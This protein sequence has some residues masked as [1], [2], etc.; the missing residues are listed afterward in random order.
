V[1]GNGSDQFKKYPNVTAVKRT[2]D[3][4]AL[5]ECYSRAGFLVNLTLEDTFPTVNLEALACGTPV[6][7]YRTGGSPETVDDLTGIVIEKHDVSGL[8]DILQKEKQSYSFLPE[9]CRERSEA[10]FDQKQTLKQYHALYETCVK[11]REKCN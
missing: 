6:I 5:A 4:N 9:H 10:Y 1:I 8:L 3:R 7:T 2:A 11:G